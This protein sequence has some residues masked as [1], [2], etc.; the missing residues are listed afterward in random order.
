MLIFCAMLLQTAQSQAREP[1][2][3]VVEVVL[4]EGVSPP[5][6]EGIAFGERVPHLDARLYNEGRVGETRLVLAYDLRQLEDVGRLVLV[7]HA[8][9]CTL[10]A[11]PG[12]FDISPFF[13]IVKPTLEMGFDPHR[14]HW[15]EPEQLA[16]Q[17]AD[18]A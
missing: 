10:L 4:G 7:R 9:G 16:A 11:T 3:R 13:R 17:A 5:S 18:S 1:A 6:C 8:E 15:V 12:D 2:A 14:L